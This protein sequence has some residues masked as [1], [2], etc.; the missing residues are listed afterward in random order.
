[1]H[2]FPYL[3][4]E[5]HLLKNVNQARDGRDAL[6]KDIYAR[7]FGWVIRRINEDLYPQR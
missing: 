1:M 7:L 6:A 5:I 2:L 4:E 3:G